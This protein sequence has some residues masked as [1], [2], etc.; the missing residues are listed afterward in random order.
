MRKNV[1]QHLLDY[2]GLA[3]K[4]EAQYLVLHLATISVYF[5]R[6]FF[7]PLLKRLPQLGRGHVV[8]ILDSHQGPLLALKA[9]VALGKLERL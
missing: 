6:K 2:V 8:R 9:M 5:Q 7:N 4:V 1:E 3:H